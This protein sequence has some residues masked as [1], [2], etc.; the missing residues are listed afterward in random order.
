[1][2]VTLEFPEE[3]EG[4]QAYRAE[5][6]AWCADKNIAP[7]YDGDFMPDGS[8]HRDPAKHEL[9]ANTVP[10]RILCMDF[11]FDGI[12]SDAMARSRE[13]DQEILFVWFRVADA[14]VC[15]SDQEI[16]ALTLTVNPQEMASYA[17]P[18]QDLPFL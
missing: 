12:L 3:Q 14:P 9:W 18:I 6:L 1:M 17:R 8:F 16:V 13:N 15:L 2:V 7:A 5:V 11:G 4:M 10:L